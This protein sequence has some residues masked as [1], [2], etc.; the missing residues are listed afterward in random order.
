MIHI[1]EGSGILSEANQ[2]DQIVETGETVI[3]EEIIDVTLTLKPAARVAIVKLEATE[4]E[5]M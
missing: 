3:G 2:E 1:L 5:S 4:R